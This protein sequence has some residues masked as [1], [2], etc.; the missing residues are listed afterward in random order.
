MPSTSGRREPMNSST[1]DEETLE[2]SNIDNISKPYEN[3]SEDYIPTNSEGPSSNN[4]HMKREIVEISTNAKKKKKADKSSWKRTVM[5][6]QRVRGKK[7]VNISESEIQEK[8]PLAFNT[9]I[10]EIIAV[11]ILLKNK[12]GFIVGDHDKQMLY[13]SALILNVPVKRR[14]AGVKNSK[15]KSSRVFL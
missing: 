4:E 1:Q 12:Q 5:K 13:L 11:E 6:N 14:K 2:E 15:G 8:N 7:Y 3:S 9:V 10:E